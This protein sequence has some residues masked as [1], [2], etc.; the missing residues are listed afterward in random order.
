MVNDNDKSHQDGADHV[1]VRD[2]RPYAESSLEFSLKLLFQYFA[3]ASHMNETA[4]Q[5]IIGPPAAL[6]IATVVAENAWLCEELSESG[7]IVSS[8]KH[9]SLLVQLSTIAE[10]HS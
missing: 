9:I 2:D 6:E 1:W 8:S 10:S 7:A 3:Y 5:N 4:L